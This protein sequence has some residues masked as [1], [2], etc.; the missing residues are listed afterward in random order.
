MRS[1]MRTIMVESAVHQIT[2]SLRW[3][4]R[5]IEPRTD[6]APPPHHYPTPFATERPVALGTPVAAILPPNVSSSRENLEPETETVSSVSEAGRPRRSRQQDTSLGDSD[7]DDTMEQVCSATEQSS[8]SLPPQR[9]RRGSNSGHPAWRGHSSSLPFFPPQTS[10][11]SS[12]TDSTMSPNIIT[13]TTDMDGGPGW[14]PGGLVSNSKERHA[15]GFP[16]VTWPPST[17]KYNFLGM[18]QLGQSN[19]QGR[20][21][22]LHRLHHEGWGLRAD[23]RIDRGTCFCR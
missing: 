22:H 17:E 20:R 6:L 1:W 2:P 16:L 8:A 5:P 18:L 7:E 9:H 23:G 10:S 19:E 3:P 21:W 14:G 4:P 11:F 15:Q 12:V 13:V